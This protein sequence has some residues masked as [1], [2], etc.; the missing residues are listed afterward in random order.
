[1]GKVQKERV[2]KMAME[3]EK[4]REPVNRKA[5]SPEVKKENAKIGRTDMVMNGKFEK[6]RIQHFH[7]WASRD[8]LG[9]VEFIRDFLKALVKRIGMTPHGDVEVHKYPTAELGFTATACVAVQ[10]LHESY[11]VFDNWIEYDPAYAN[12]VVN[13]CKTFNTVD[14]VTLINELIQPVHMRTSSPDYYSP[15]DK[16]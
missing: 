7:I 5:G 1:M 11:I 10:H 13:S 14:V 9:N 2:L 15:D 12:I 4:A 8:K 16:V 3:V 6:G